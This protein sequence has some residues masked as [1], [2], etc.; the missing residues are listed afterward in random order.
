[1]FGNARGL[2]RP[3]RATAAAMQ[4][5]I[6]AS[7]AAAAQT[8]VFLADD[9]AATGVGGTFY[10]PRR[11]PRHV[12]ER[13]RRPERRAALWAASEELVRPWLSDFGQPHTLPNRQGEP[14]SRME[15]S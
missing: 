13:V 2:P 7:P 5:L 6:G 10:G 14:S 12:P 4:R 9:P 1:M 8:P 11:R 15:K 3:V